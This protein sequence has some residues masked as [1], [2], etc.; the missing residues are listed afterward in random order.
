[1]KCPK[2]EAELEALDAYSVEEN[3]QEVTL[4]EDGNLDWSA[5]D[6]VEDTCTCIEFECPT[7]K[8]TIYK[9]RGNSTDPHIKE[10]LS[11]TILDQVKELE[12][13]TQVQKH[14]SQEWTPDKGAKLN[15]YYR[16]LCNNCNNLFLS[17]RLCCPRCGSL[18]IGVGAPEPHV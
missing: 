10:L 11:P 12:Q 17:T 7:C 4:D 13:E 16:M 14:F 2:C 9:N 18:N 8:E 5:S 15:A 6:P 1:M 3:K